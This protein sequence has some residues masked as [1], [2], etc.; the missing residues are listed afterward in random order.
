MSGT[1]IDDKTPSFVVNIPSSKQGSNEITWS[2]L[3][4]KVDGVIVETID[5]SM[6]AGTYE[7]TPKTLMTN[8]E[9]NVSFNLVG[10]LSTGAKYESTYSSPYKVIISDVDAVN[11]FK[12]ADPWTVTFANSTVSVSDGYNWGA[13]GNL[14]TNDILPY[15]N[16]YKL[17]IKNASGIYQEITSNQDTRID[18]GSAML[19]DFRKDGTFV[20]DPVNF[21]SNLG[22]VG[23]FEYRITDLATGKSDT[24]TVTYDIS[25]KNI[26]MN[27]G[28]EAD[29][30][31]GV[32]KGTTGDDILV[33]R[34]A[35]ETITSGS[36]QDVLIY[37]LLKNANTGGNVNS[38]S[39]DIWTDFQ[40]ASV[41]QGGDII[42]VTG[43]LQ[44]SYVTTSN[45][46]R[47]LKVTTS[48]G[49][50]VISVDVDGTGI[51]K[52]STPLLVLENT[53]TTLDE[54]MRNGQILF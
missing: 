28:V 41:N 15:G 35:S 7:W 40:V 52:S 50:T 22:K 11:D 1:V 2:K 3:N 6:K 53:N 8:G 47:Y 44:D 31:T 39:T 36:G 34:G 43:L 42:D 48:N 37:N 27:R 10:T 17:E 29:S 46:S 38:G 32:L 51:G 9:H 49:S 21:S 16:N 33:S 4:V 30:G 14:F 24:A 25:A 45:I 20:L 12:T 26:I 5:I 54:L 19:V 13:T 18:F 23:S